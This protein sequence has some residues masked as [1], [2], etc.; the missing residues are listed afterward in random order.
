MLRWRLNQYITTTDHVASQY[1]IVLS[2]PSIQGI[3]TYSHCHKIGRKIPL[4]TQKSQKIGC[5]LL[6]SALFLEFLTSKKKVPY[7][8]WSFEV[9]TDHLM[10]EDT[11]SSCNFCNQKIDTHQARATREDCFAGVDTLTFH[12]H[13]MMRIIKGGMLPGS[14]TLVQFHWKP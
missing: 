8:L 12:H 1:R 3:N 2:A 9:T 11:S 13:V 10:L 6:L 4:G 7:G 14:T 5:G